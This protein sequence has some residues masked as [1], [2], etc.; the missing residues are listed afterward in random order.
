M[1][2]NAF[3]M[4]LKPG[5]EDEYRRRHEAI[6]PELKRELRSAGISDYSIYLDRRTGTLFAHQHLADHHTLGDLPKLA[7]MRKWWDAMAELMETNPDG[8]PV[9][10]PLDEV[11]QLD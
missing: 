6:W 1:T 9:V 11:F 2:R 4:K 3:L 7:I 5:Q 10:V 8:S